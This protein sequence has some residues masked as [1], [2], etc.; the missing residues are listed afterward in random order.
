MFPR[1]VKL[2]SCKSF[3]RLAGCM[4]CY[5]LQFVTYFLIFD[6]MSTIYRDMDTNNQGSDVS[7]YH[8]C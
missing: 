2:E 7:I 3:E 6:T 8:V 1:E 5:I 4:L